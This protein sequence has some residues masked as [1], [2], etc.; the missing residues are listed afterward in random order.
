MV[1]I[2]AHGFLLMVCGYLF[3][4]I[5]SGMPPLPP[6]SGFFKTWLYNIF[7]ILGASADKVV[8][9]DPRIA[10]LEQS[11]KKIDSD[12]TETQSTTKAVNTSGS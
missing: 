3:A 8:K 11:T 9:H 2:N 10:V 12:G 1:W 5:V 7:Q 4:L 6:G